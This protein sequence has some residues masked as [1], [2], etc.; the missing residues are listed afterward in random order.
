V[1]LTVR[2]LGL[3]TRESVFHTTVSGLE[4]LF[5]LIALSY[6]PNCMDNAPDASRALQIH[7][8]RSLN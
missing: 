3:E 8:T 5:K 2:S 7:Q 6:L 4:T 1:A